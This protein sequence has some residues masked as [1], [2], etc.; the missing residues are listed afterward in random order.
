MQ[1]FFHILLG[2]LGE[3][4]Y[5]SLEANRYNTKKSNNNNPNLMVPKEHI[6]VYC[7]KTKY[8]QV[9]GYCEI[10]NLYYILSNV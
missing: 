6:P 1:Y 5:H 9:Q 2:D 4:L 3:Y 8:S 10:K 7:L